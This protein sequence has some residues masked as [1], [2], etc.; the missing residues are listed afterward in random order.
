MTVRRVKVACGVQVP[1]LRSAVCSKLRRSGTVAV[2]SPGEANEIVVLG[3][4]SLP[5]NQVRDASWRA[6]LR[7]AGR[8]FALDSDSADDLFLFAR[9]LETCFVVAFENGSGHWR[10]SQTLRNWYADDPVASA[11]GVEVFP[12]VSFSTLVLDGL[13][14]GVAFDAGFLNRTALSV[15][16][17]FAPNL[18]AHV[19]RE[20]GRQFD[21]FRNRTERRKGTLLYT[22]GEQ[23]VPVCYFDRFADGVTC[24]STGPVRDAKSLHAYCQARYPRLLLSPADTV[25]RV[26][27]PGLPHAVPVPAKFLRVRVMADEENSFRGLSGF[28]TL[29]P[30]RRRDEAVRAWEAHRGE[31]E[32]LLGCRLHAQLWQPGADRCELL[33]CPALQFG[34]GRTIAAPASATVPEYRRYYQDRL[35]R[36]K[37]NGL[38]E[39]PAAV[40]RKVHVVTPQSGAGWTDALQAAFLGDVGRALQDMA[41]TRFTLVP[42]REDDPERVVEFLGRVEERQ[43]G[44]GAAMVVFDDRRADGA[45]Y[46]LLSHGLKGWFLKRMTRGLLIR[47]WEERQSPRGRGGKPEAERRWQDVITLSALDLLDQMGATP[48]RIASWPYDA[49]LAIDVGEGRRHFA[50]SLLVCRGNDAAPSFVRI[51]DSWPKGDHQHEAINRV[52]LRDKMVQLFESYQ[53]DDFVPIRSLLAVRDGHMQDGEVEA[54]REAVDRLQ[55]KERVAQ[56]AHV[57]FAEVRKRTSKSLRMWLAGG[58][59]CANVLEGQAVYLDGNAAL[60]SCTGAATLSQAVTADPCV[61]AAHGGADV[62]RVARAYFALSQLN[63]SSPG[64]AHRAAQPIRETDVRLQ[65]R[66]AEDMRGVK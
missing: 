46:Y 37:G 19:R 53:A 42:V 29:S 2:P 28:K 22:T 48:W 16:D 32:G 3:G 49:C 38:Y 23:V 9:L 66:M 7:D 44:P 45:A 59:G 65:Q 30:A 5:T 56:S 20:R 13:G 47:R 26:S 54:M 21:R 11:D 60:V 17:F 36:L 50:M 61:L 52:M 6:E 39:F 12:R 8:P 40:E 41:G 33:P 15:A 58:D 31:V 51:S 55:K 18:P 1:G 62:R 4:G 63:Y 34:S 35:T 10:L 25:A 43:G 57:D 64:K 27:F 24:G 14:V